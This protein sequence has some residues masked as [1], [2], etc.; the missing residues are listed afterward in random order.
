MADPFRWVGLTRSINRWIRYS[1][2][3]ADATDTVVT[4]IIPMPKNQTDT[5]RAGSN[6][7]ITP[8]ISFGID[9]SE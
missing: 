1:N 9:S 6:E 3:T 5:A 7:I 8:Y 4:M 2:R